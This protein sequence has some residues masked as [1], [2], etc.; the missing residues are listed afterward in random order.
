MTTKFYK[1]ALLSKDSVSEERKGL[2]ENELKNLRARFKRRQNKFSTI[3][4]TFAPSSGSDEE[5]VFEK[6]DVEISPINIETNKGE[7]GALLNKDALLQ[8]KGANILRKA[9][10]V[11]QG[12]CSKSSSKTE[13][14]TQSRSTSS[15]TDSINKPEASISPAPPK[16]RIKSK[17]KSSGT[18]SPLKSKTVK[19]KSVES[20]PTKIKGKVKEGVDERKKHDSKNKKRKE[21]KNKSHGEFKIHEK[22]IK[23]SKNHK[24]KE[25]IKDMQE[26]KGM[27]IVLTKSEEKNPKD[28]KVLHANVEGLENVVALEN[29]KLIKISGKQVKSETSKFN[30]YKSPIKAE[31]LPANISLEGYPQNTSDINLLL[32]PI[33]MTKKDQLLYEKMDDE[34]VLDT[35]LLQSLATDLVTE[36][37]KV[38]KD[39]IGEDIAKKLIEIEKNDKPLIEDHIKDEKEVVISETARRIVEALT[40]NQVLGKVLTPEEATI[41]RDYFSRKIPL[42]EQVLATLDTALDKI[43]CR[44]YEF[45]DD[46]KELD[47]FLK[48]RDSAK[49]KLLDALIAKKS[50]YLADLMSDASFYA[51]RISKGLIDVYKLATEGILVARDNLQYMQ[52]AV[53]HT[54]RYSKDMAYRGAALTYETAA[55]GKELAEIGASVGAQMTYDAAKMTLDAAVRGKELAEQGAAIGTKMTSD[56]A[57]ITLDAAVRGKELAERGAAIG[58]KMTS[59]AAKMTLDAAVRGKELAERGAA[60]GTKMTSDAAKMT[61]DAAVRG[62]E[63]AERGAAIGTKMTSD[64]AKMT[65][66]AAVRGKELAE[67]G[68]AIGTKMTSDA[69]KMTLDAAVFGKELA[70]RGAAI[71]TTIASDAAKM[72]YDVTNRG[73]EL[74]GLGVAIGAKVTQDAASK[75]LQIAEG[76]IHIASKGKEMVKDS[77]TAVSSTS[78]DLSETALE[79][80]L[81]ATKLVGKKVQD[82]TGAMNQAKSEIQKSSEWFLSFFQPST[83]TSETSSTLKE[84]EDNDDDSN[85]DESDKDETSLSSNKKSGVVDE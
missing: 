59:D 68:A 76:T 21:E 66:D 80:A 65:L 36:S 74:A 69:A 46:K 41:L 17:E 54:Y 31:S 16:K 40:S 73:K 25:D 4:V 35:N 26:K 78:L 43:L 67:R 52:A 58:T 61:L 38:N 11:A 50:N 28:I 49:G 71:G 14:V 5:E 1:L 55:R 45:Y 72:T 6:V 51:D 42:S 23:R 57:K 24:I 19:I 12:S 9:D 32:K 33:E 70:E 77:L 44:A 7:K 56:A 47:A 20:Q 18:I 39:I 15:T 82:F 48:D 2:T 34:I 27:G 10:T 84:V 53:G 81:E 13:Q 8:P 75:G 64:A 22:K 29:E 62:K 30:S 83:T 79:S 63:L 3:T 37:S 60:I 85:D